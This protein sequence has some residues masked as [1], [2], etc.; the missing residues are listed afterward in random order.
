MGIVFQKHYVQDGLP[1]V[2][3]TVPS[4]YF[5]NQ[6]GRSKY[7][8]RYNNLSRIKNF[9]RT[10]KLAHQ[11]D[12]ENVKE[13]ILV[14]KEEKAVIASPLKLFQ[15]EGAGKSDDLNSKFNNEIISYMAEG[16]EDFE[17][18]ENFNLDKESRSF[19][20]NVYPYLDE[21]NNLSISS[22]VFSQFNCVKAVAKFVDSPVVAGPWETRYQLFQ[23][24]GKHIEQEIKQL[25]G[26]SIKGD[27]F[28]EVPSGIKTINWDQFEIIDANE[29]EKEVLYSEADLVLPTIWEVDPSNDNDEPI[30]IFSFLSPVDNYSGEVKKLSGTLSLSDSGTFNE[31]D[32]Y[33]EVEI[34]DVTMGA[35]DFDYEVQNKML[36]MVSF[37]K[38][39]FAFDKVETR[40]EPLKFGKTTKATVEG[41]FTMTGISIPIVV[42]TQI[43]PYL[44]SQ[45][46]PRLLA[47]CNFEIPLFDRFKIEG[48]DGPSPAK[49]RLQFFMK[50]NLKEKIN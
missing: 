13:T 21:Y 11:K 17:I 35:E 47:N 7:Y 8:G 1:D 15:I 33:F 34:S 16:M 5:Q 27:A 6:K 14:W 10:S 18:F 30:I 22:E 19:Y 31:S 38:A 29:R 26:H 2:V 4:I 3:S 44:S 40:D 45:G 42:D 43:E 46:E 25:I 9:I 48:P 12:S 41:T 32:G 23:E 36:K 39:S 37:P 24:F 20:V 50:F 49:D 28:K